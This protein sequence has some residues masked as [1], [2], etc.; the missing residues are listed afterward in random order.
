[1]RSDD[2]AMLSP[3]PA[4]VV[5]L[6]IL[7]FNGA[8]LLGDCLSS[9]A[10]QS[11][12]DFE[13]VLVDNGSTDESLAR[14]EQLW[15]AARV[16]PLSRNLGF[17]EGNNVGIRA[18]HGK[19]IVLL[20]NDTQL[21][22][23]F[24][25]ELVRIADGDERIGMVAPKILNFFD[26]RRIDSV[27]GLLLCP[28]GLAQGRGRGEED[29][30]QYDDLQEVLVPSACA[31]LYRREMLDEIGL[32]DE[33]FFMYCEDTDLGLRARWAG[34]RAVAAPQAVV[35]HKYSGSSSA[36]SPM[37]MYYVERNHYLVALKN[38]PWP[39]LLAVP[40]G[41]LHR[42]LLM[43]WALLARRAQGPAKRPGS[44]LHAFVRGNLAGLL[45]GG[46]SL[47]RRP[48]L[49]RLSAKQFRRLV[50]GHRLSARRLVS[51]V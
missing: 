27:G 2:A 17:A 38:F 34:W 39:M 32:L 23:R 48:P 24:L 28:D 16:I 35:Y 18:A 12:Q 40:L 29:L 21:G 1:M 13:V 22:P 25:E 5:S 49:R 31:A 46:R 19:Y 20:N 26:R 44:L 50:R 45:R 37:K 11:F 33:D 42:W 41:T 15:P 6:V 36:Y 3:R 7:N 47:L 14:V 51:R 30:G 9:I 4:P 8:A 43:A 10:E